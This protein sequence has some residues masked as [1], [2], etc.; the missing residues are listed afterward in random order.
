[1][2]II[3]GKNPRKFKFSMKSL[4]MTLC[5]FTTG[6]EMLYNDHLGTIKNHISPLSKHLHN[7]V[8]EKEPLCASWQHRV[9]NST[10][11]YSEGHGRVH[12]T[13]TCHTW[14]PRMLVSLTFRMISF[15]WK[16]LIYSQ[17]HDLRAGIPTPNKAALFCLCKGYDL[18]LWHIHCS[19][20]DP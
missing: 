19:N 4:V 2:Y 9:G 10:H 20:R 15:S 6:E 7:S 1:M 18:I 16:E 11:K 17:K 3:E 5:K 12:H 8:T 13:V 14:F